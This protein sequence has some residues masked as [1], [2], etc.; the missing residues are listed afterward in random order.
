MGALKFVAIDL[1]VRDSGRKSSQPREFME[2]YWTVEVLKR[3][4][5]V[6]VRSEFVEEVGPYESG[7]DDGPRIRGKSLQDID[8]LYLSMAPQCVEGNSFQRPA[9]SG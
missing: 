9:R 7:V 8:K 2:G 4:F 3:Q 6:S 5:D 1:Q